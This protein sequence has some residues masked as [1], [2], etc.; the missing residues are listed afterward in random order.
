MFVLASVDAFN[1][2]QKKAESDNV[3]DLAMPKGD[4]PRADEANLDK[5]GQGKAAA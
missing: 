1:G 5:V 2:E 4:E 3:G